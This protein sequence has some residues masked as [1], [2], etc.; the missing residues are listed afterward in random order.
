MSIKLVARRRVGT[1]KGAGRRIRDRGMIPAILYGGGRENVNLAIEPGQVKQVLQSARGANAVF[2][3]QVEGGE[4]AEHVRIVDYTKHPL[5][6][7]LVHCDFQRVDPQKPLK[8]L[9]PFELTGTSDAAKLGSKIRFVTRHVWVKSLPA[10]IPVCVVV[11]QAA[12]VPGG[13]IRLA[14]IKAP[15]GVELLYRDNAPIVVAQSLSA[16]EATSEEAEAAEET[17]STEAEE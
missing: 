9:V 6:R 16:S 4:L 11:D 3:L 10:D 2:P 17:E 1:G 8:S 15:D 12:L 13:A 7:T 14:D 5:K